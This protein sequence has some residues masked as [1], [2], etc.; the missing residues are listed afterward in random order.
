[1]A[2]QAGLFDLQDRYAELS[3][4]VSVVIAPFCSAGGLIAWICNGAP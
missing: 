3:K 4:S 2:G 1:M